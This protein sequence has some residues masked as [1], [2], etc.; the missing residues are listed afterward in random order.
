ML[1]TPDLKRGGFAND[2]GAGLSLPFRAFGAVFS[3]G[4]LF[5]LAA[6]SALIALAVLVA[7]FLFVTHVSPVDLF[8]QE[9]TTWYA[10]ALYSSLKFVLAVV[11]FVSGALTL[12]LLATVP[13]QD[14]ISK[15]TEKLLGADVEGAGLGRMAR[16]ISNSLIHTV[17]RVL[18]LYLGQ[19]AL[20]LLLVIPGIGQV[21]WTVLSWLWSIW[22]AAGEYLD[23]P[24]G[25]HLYRFSEVRAVLRA[26]PALCLSFGAVLYVLLF[27]PILNCFVIPVAVIAGTMLFRGLV[28]AGVVRPPRE[29]TP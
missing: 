23:I 26:R 11:I 22:W 5:S 13:L 3:E 21:A 1:A 17:S 27:V 29:L 18:L 16:E 8:W 14:S 4:A 6:L 10:R 15:R 25:R 12:P 9:P 2:L 20:L 28:S 7:L 24:M 19:L